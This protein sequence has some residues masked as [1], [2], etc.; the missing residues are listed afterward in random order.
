VRIYILYDGDEQEIGEV[1][2]GAAR[3][4]TDLVSRRVEEIA[5]D[6]VGNFMESTEITISIR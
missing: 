2:Y 5:D 3:I 4:D 6:L 1:E